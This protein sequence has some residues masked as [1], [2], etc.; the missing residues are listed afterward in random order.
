MIRY[1]WLAALL[2]ATAVLAS[3][4][5][6][7]ERQASAPSA[8]QGQSASPRPSTGASLQ[9]TASSP[10]TNQPAPSLTTATP[11]PVAQPTS[12]PP[13]LPSPKTTQPTPTEVTI[14]S[15]TSPVR[16]GANATVAVKTAPGA[17]CSIIVIY[18]SGPSEAQG[19]YPKT[20]D[21]Q[22]SVSWKWMV[23][24]R[25]TPGNWPVTITCGG[26]TARTSISVN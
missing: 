15:I 3:S 16:R 7:P 20:A 17:S 18:K 5:G 26:V 10:T 14:T 19:L 12:T 11:K 1:R 23:G 25:T 13:T 9:G 24:T 22:G 21:S 8:Q 2:V 6:T 4:C